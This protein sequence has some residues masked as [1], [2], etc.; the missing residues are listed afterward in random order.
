MS[1][2]VTVTC[3]GHRNTSPCPAAFWAPD[4]VSPPEARLAAAAEG[5][6]LSADGELCPD[7]GHDPPPVPPQPAPQPEPAQ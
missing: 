2:H 7:P 4:S 3:D 5:W 6:Q 1:W